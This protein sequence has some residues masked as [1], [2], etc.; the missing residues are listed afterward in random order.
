[1]TDQSELE[2][3]RYFL[4]DTVRRTIDFSE[5]GQSRG[6]RPPPIEKPFPK[7]AKRVDLVPPGPFECIIGPDGSAAVT[8]FTKGPFDN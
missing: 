2:R 3:Y 5:T 7:D 1:M 6:V 4:K 8:G